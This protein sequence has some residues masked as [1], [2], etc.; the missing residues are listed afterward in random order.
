MKKFI[1]FIIMYFFIGSF[2]STAPAFAGNFHLSL[3]RMHES[4][5][6]TSG[7]LSLNGK[8]IAYTLELPEVGN[9][10]NIS[11]IPAGR[12]KGFIRYDHKDHWRIELQDFPADYSGRRDHVQIHIGNT[13]KDS[14]GCILVGRKVNADMCTLSDSARAYDDMRS[15]FYGR[16]D[17]INMPDSE[18]ILTVSDAQL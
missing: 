18:A 15:A 8:I 9:I 6:C 10:G 12:Y 3:Q 2:A 4:S 13:T 1:N 16:S 7:Q 17:P 14:K 11:R 5:R